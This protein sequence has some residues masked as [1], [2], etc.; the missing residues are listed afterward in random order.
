MSVK[1]VCA[2]GTSL[3]VGVQS[4]GPGA[5]GSRAVAPVEGAATI[6]EM[7]TRATTT[8]APSPRLLSPIDSPIVV[9]RRAL[10]VVGPPIPAPTAGAVGTV[11]RHA[12]VPRGP[13]PRRTAHRG[14][15]R[16]TP[17]RLP[18]HLVHGVEDVRARA[19]GRRRTRAPGGCHPRQAPHDALRAGD[20]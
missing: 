18:G 20:V 12:G 13:S 19:R 16:G 8:A 4:G 7:A 1:N 2:H 14:L 5:R 15:S 3:K 6:A 9:D 10:T 17:H 11:R